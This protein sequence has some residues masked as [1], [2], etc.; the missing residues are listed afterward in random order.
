MRARV[1]RCRRSP[2]DGLRASERECALQEH[3][4]GLSS[5]CGSVNHVVQGPCVVVDA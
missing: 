5:T 1:D 2:D 3:G 4:L